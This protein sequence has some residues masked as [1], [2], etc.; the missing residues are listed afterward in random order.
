MR[1]PGISSTTFDNISTG[2][3][4]GDFT[5]RWAGG[6]I[7]R[8]KHFGWL[9]W[10]SL[11]ILDSLYTAMKHKQ[12]EVACPFKT[13]IEEHYREVGIQDDATVFSHLRKMCNG[14]LRVLFSGEVSDTPIVP[15]GDYCRSSISTAPTEAFCLFRSVIREALSPSITVA[16]FEKRLSNVNAQGDSGVNPSSKL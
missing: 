8:I 7:D 13:W 2:H 15:S 5:L 12:A 3:E 9:T 4:G 6:P 11:A 10:C 14:S 16:E 1:P